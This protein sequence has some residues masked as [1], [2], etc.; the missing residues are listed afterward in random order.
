[1]F[2]SNVR[3]ALRDT[4]SSTAW[5]WTSVRVT[6]D[7]ELNEVINTNGQTA[8]VTLKNATQ[9]ERFEG[10]FA[11][12]N[13]TI[14]KRW[15]TQAATAT[16]DSDLRKQWSDGTIGV[17]TILASDVFD[18][19]ENISLSD[20]QRITFGGTDA[21]IETSDWGTNL[22]F[23]DSSNAVRSLTELSASG[24]N[25]SVRVTTNDTTP[26]VLNNKLTAG[27]GLS[28]TTASPGSNETLDLDID[29]SDTA[30]FSTTQWTAD[31]AIKTDG[32]GNIDS[33][34]AA[35]T[36]QAGIMR[37]ATSTEA[38]EWTV[39]DVAM[40]PADVAN[41]AARNQMVASNELQASADT[42]RTEN[43]WNLT[44][45]KEIEVWKYRL[46]GTVRI[47]FEARWQGTPW[48][49]NAL[50]Q[51]R[52]NGNVIASYDENN[53]T[54]VYQEF[55]NDVTV[56]VWDLLQLYMSG[57][58][59]PNTTAYVR[60]FRMKFDAITASLDPVVNTD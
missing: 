27:D 13:F 51:L 19:Q 58:N 52:L 47:T 49:V 25:D 34:F 14:S 4:L 44:K 37:F 6:N 15:L 35:S 45:F 41:N 18:A 5:A 29:L 1:M 30:I 42:E 48:N 22:N 43:Q 16:E 2:L 3:F 59:N 40:T 11:A 20:N 9:I 46:W 60:N 8:S 33:S 7:F 56:E 10:T 23:K 24:A 21:Y 54:Q 50:F 26:S 12:G 55:S 32:S 53:T 28:K 17:I 39:T 57:D 38:S 36:T 31:R